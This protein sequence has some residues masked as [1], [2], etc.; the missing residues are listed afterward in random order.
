MTDFLAG[1]RAESSKVDEKKKADVLTA[2]LD[3]SVMGFRIELDDP[4]VSRS[5]QGIFKFPECV[6]GEIRSYCKDI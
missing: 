4:S 3:V 5:I 1:P 6:S 2:H